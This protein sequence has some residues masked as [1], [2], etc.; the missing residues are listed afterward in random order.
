MLHR[1]VVQAKY[2][3]KTQ[4]CVEKVAQYFKKSQEYVYRVIFKSISKDLM[5]VVFRHE[6]TFNGLTIDIA[7]SGLQKY[8]RRGMIDKAIWC[9]IE[10]D[11]FA[12]IEKGERIRT[13]FI[14]RL[15]IIYLEDISI[16]NL[17]LWV[18]LNNWIF[19]LLSLRLKRKQP[20]ADFISIRE[21]EEKLVI[22]IIFQLCSSQH[23]R[24]LS[25]Y[26]A[27]FVNFSDLTQKITQL[28]Y[29]NNP[30]L[31]FLYVKNTDKSLAHNI[32]NKLVF[33]LD[34]IE[35]VNLQVS[36][37]IGA[38][39]HKDPRAFYWANEILINLEKTSKHYGKSK[40]TYLLF[41]ILE[42]FINTYH[43]NLSV[44]FK[45]GLQWFDELHVKESF[46]CYTILIASII[47]Y[48]KVKSSIDSFVLTPLY[49]NYNASYKKNLT[50]YVI[51][52]DKFV[53]DMHTAA[54]RNLKQGKSTFVIKGAYVS[55]EST[56]VNSDYKN[57][58]TDVGI[59]KEKGLDFLKNKYPCVK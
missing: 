48:D 34:P 27:I 7:K 44:Y 15:M 18:P 50:G 39:E 8:I 17:G 46:L 23:S 55:N 14:H 29:K 58:Y 38:L 56:L 35:N 2:G 21:R 24:V 49:I 40:K 31:S 9:G 53:V 42:K 20:D 37:F 6:I 52:I 54:G 3:K 33:K 10:L 45:I 22:K 16:A 25:H 19:K 30:L 43:P 1:T 59:A 13:N 36:N 51:E 5:S 57:L 11:L 4:E 32:P 41:S 12:F 26:N 28:Y 47:H